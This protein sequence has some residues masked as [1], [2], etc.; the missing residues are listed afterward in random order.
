MKLDDIKL[1]IET[2]QDSDE[3]WAMLFH[4]LIE[5]SVNLKSLRKKNSR[6]E[7]F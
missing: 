1:A 3:N 4:E 2:S 7:N 5:R 6:P